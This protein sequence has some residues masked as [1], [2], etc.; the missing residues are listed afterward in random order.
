MYLYKRIEDAKI[1]IDRNYPDKID[2]AHIAKK[3]YLSKYH[4][5]RLFKEAYGI[6]PY[7]YLTAKRIE[8]AKKLLLTGLSVSHTCKEVG[9]ESVH[10][11]SHLFKKYTGTSPGAFQ[12]KANNT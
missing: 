8:A 11:F 5:L 3:V 6:S 12:K 4:F 2:L 10:S 7:Q 9:F 1:L